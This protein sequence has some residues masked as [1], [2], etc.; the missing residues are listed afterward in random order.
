MKA[1]EISQLRNKSVDELKKMVS[2]KKVELAKI[3]IDIKISRQKNLK[4]ARFMRKDIARI[5]SII[6]MWNYQNIK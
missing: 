4:A 6:S 2:E 1:K 5:L 3:R